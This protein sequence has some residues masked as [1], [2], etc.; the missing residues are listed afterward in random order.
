MPAGRF[1]CQGCWN[2]KLSSDVA[3]AWLLGSS[4]A[5][6]EGCSKESSGLEATVVWMELS[7]CS[8]TGVGAGGMEVWLGYW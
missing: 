8:G 3:V 7:D 1:S 6:A 4:V 2:R 5:D